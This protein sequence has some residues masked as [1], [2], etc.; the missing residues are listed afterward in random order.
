VPVEEKAKYSKTSNRPKRK[1]IAIKMG[2]QIRVD[3]FF[4]SSSPATYRKH[5]ARYIDLRLKKP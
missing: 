1:L 4:L 3:Q 5:P 2:A